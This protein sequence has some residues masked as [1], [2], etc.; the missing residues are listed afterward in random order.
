MCSIEAHDI[1]HK[2]GNDN[3]SS[4]GDKPLPPE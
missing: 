4:G 3:A 1:L 2:T